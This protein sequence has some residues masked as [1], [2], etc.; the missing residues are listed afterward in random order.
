MDSRLHAPLYRTKGAD[1]QQWPKSEVE[2]CFTSSGRMRQDPSSILGG[3]TVLRWFYI[4]SLKIFSKNN[5]NV[6]IVPFKRL[7]CNRTPFKY[8]FRAWFISLITFFNIAKITNQKLRQ[9]WNHTPSER[10]RGPV[11]KSDA[12]L[13]WR[14]TRYR[15]HCRV[16][17]GT[18]GAMKF[19]SLLPMFELR[20]SDPLIRR[21]MSK[22]GTQTGGQEI[23]S[24][25]SDTPFLHRRVDASTSRQQQND[26]PESMSEKVELSLWVDDLTAIG[27]AFSCDEGN[28]RLSDGKTRRLK[29]L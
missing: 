25:T 5:D 23:C 11:T 12:D 19:K 22:A 26:N 29:K 28:V 13:W 24:G 3:G 9:R 15:R 16:F 14:E 21:T 8:H 17:V 7:Y 10:S 27:T 4:T 2:F 18:G 6:I 20:Q 1:R